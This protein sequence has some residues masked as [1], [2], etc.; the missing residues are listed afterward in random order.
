VEREVLLTSAQKLGK[1]LV[2]LAGDTHNAWSSRLT[3][4]DGSV[5]G[6]EFA[7]PSIS[8][9]GLEA[10]LATLTPGRGSEDLSGGC[11]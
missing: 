2:V 5:V 1:K 11:G 10:Y 7:T 3:L 4:M 8:S 6:Q 9:P